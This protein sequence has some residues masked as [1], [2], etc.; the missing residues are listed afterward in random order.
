MSTE[1]YL[2][3]IVALAFVIWGPKKMKMGAFVVFL[4]MLF[5]IF[6]PFRQNM[7]GVEI[8]TDKSGNVNVRDGSGTVSIPRN[9]AVR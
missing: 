6:S 8:S 7:S 2:I 1:T 4:V 9:G 5:I 3:A